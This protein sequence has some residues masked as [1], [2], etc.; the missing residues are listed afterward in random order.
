MASVAQLLL[1]I[2][3]DGSSAERTIR[4]VA[5]ETKA[6][7]R[8]NVAA[9]VDAN[10]Q[11]A[12]EN[13]RAVSGDLRGISAAPPTQT[14]VEVLIAGA[15]VEIDRVTKRLEALARQAPSPEVTVRTAKA[16]VQLDRLEQKLASIGRQEVQPTVS[17]D[18][19]AIQAQLAQIPRQIV[20][21]IT[22]AGKIAFAGFAAQAA[23][24]AA[25]AATAFGGALAPLAGLAGAG[26]V[27]LSALKQATIVTKV[28]MLGLTPLLKDFKKALMEPGP[29]VAV[30]RAALKP[31][32]PDLIA[33]RNTAQAG[34]L[35]GLTDSVA[36]ARPVLGPLTTVVRA[37]SGA[38]G[39]LA[40]QA[41][42]L[43]GSAGF[44][45]D[46]Q[47]IGTRNASIIRVLGGAAIDLGNA[48]RHIL[49]AA[50]PLTS[51]L[52]KMAAG[53]A[54]G[55]A[56]QA[57]AGRESGR[58]AAFFER[59]RQVVVRL[60][61][62]GGSFFGVLGDIGRAAAPL[63]GR[64]L[65]AFD[66]A[67]K[68]LRDVTSSASGQNALKKYFDDIE[69]ALMESGRLVRDIGKA[70]IE[71]ANQPG[72]EILIR[73]IRTQLL[74]ALTEIVKGTTAAFGPALVNALTQV[75]RL[76]G[77]FVGSSG[78]LVVMVQTLGA[79]AGALATIIEK[80]PGLQQLLVAV[81]GVAAV[82]K[83]LQFGAAVTGIKS[84]VGSVNAVR[85]AQ[86]GSTAAAV[87]GRAAS[88][89][90]A[91]A[92]RARAAAS[93][94]VGVAQRG[95]AAATNL[96]TGAN[97]RARVATLAATAAT[98]AG[99]VAAKAAAVAQGA[100]NLVLAAN[101]IGLIVVALVALVAGLIYAYKHS[102][103]FRNIVDGAFN[104][105]KGV[106]IPVVNAIIDIVRVVA[107]VIADVA[108]KIVGAVGKIGGVFRALVGVATTAFN[109]VKGVVTGALGAVGSAISGAAGA[110]RTAGSTAFNAVKDG[111][112]AVKGAVTGTASTIG[113]AAV[114]AV[115][116]VA[117]AAKS[118]GSTVFNAAKDGISAVGGAV[119]S[120]AHT[121]ASGA[122]S[123]VRDAADN[124]KNAGS[125]VGNAVRSGLSSAAGAVRN[126]GQS[127]GSTALSAIRGAASGAANIG[128]DIVRGIANGIRGA[129]GA[130]T[131]AI[132]DVVHGAISR[133]K[134]MLGIGSPSKVFAGMGVNI[135][136]GLANG[137]ASQARQVNGALT[138]LV[139][140]TL[141]TLSPQ[142][143]LRGLATPALTDGGAA[144][145]GGAA[146]GSVTIQNAK[147]GSQQ[148]AQALAERLAFRMSFG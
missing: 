44:G 39:D 54:S 42:T 27:G 128:G 53:F 114:S 76:L 95:V 90:S 80:V 111:F 144:G 15:Q 20:S 60:V 142:V 132:G 140:A 135:G 122:V 22:Q 84:L 138:G 124:A 112:N 85:L 58:L 110:F 147:I 26:A 72:V 105:V 106:V 123:A 125:A 127:I 109:A 45:R 77:A 63:G 79:M 16:T 4:G 9:T 34:L 32:G 81:A 145:A 46:L 86:E 56:E 31:L 47:A 50:G 28:A 30:L 99:S 119:K 65:A 137:I 96:I 116:A 102:E 113:K 103:T 21:T 13:L 41:A 5:D 88:V 2:T 33:L 82:S 120:A 62:I 100:L 94:A 52:A 69:P 48:L 10:V 59:T 23:G 6:L 141:P 97:V 17:I 83:A 68:G 93:V 101:P 14:R 7:G 51:A 117:G 131:G 91:V 134:G 37:T 78:P 146:P 40:R 130:V 139:D 70:F 55:V 104:A 148:A 8:L 24:G 121:V 74:P 12:R 3:G 35:K 126:A 66:G 25:A 43:V 71:L 1:R 129:A 87:R 29:Q 75:T 89:A 36:L 98:I 38:L 118:A 64:L 92:D 11:A 49:V 19:N 143:A 115:S 18:R 61:S 108:G 73:A 133:A 57:K 136:E 107:G 67:L